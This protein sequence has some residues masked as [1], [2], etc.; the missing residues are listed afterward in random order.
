MVEDEALIIAIVVVGIPGSLAIAWGFW[1]RRLSVE[2]RQE[3]AR[4]LE[5]WLQRHPF[6]AGFWKFLKGL[7]LLAVVANIIFKANEMRITNYR[8]ENYKDQVII[9][10]PTLSK[11]NK[12]SFEMYN[13]M[14]TIWFHAE[15]NKPETL[16]IQ[17]WDGTSWV[18]SQLP[19]PPTELRKLESLSTAFL[20]F[21]LP[22]SKVPFRVGVVWFNPQTNERGVA[23]SPKLGDVGGL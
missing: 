3:E 2:Q 7:G 14:S 10:E 5:M 23:W 22:P 11:E 21:N 15:S 6:V 9:L 1:R 8:F 17:T 12:L 18:T 20:K 16:G 13:G 4:K 19:A